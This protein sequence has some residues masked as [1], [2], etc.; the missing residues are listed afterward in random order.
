MAKTI[1]TKTKMALSLQI[2]ST[3][4]PPVTNEFFLASFL[5]Y[6]VWIRVV[7]ARVH[8]TTIMSAGAEPLDRIAALGQMTQLFAQAVEDTLSTLIAWSIWATKR[9]LLLADI[10][11]RISLRLAVP[12]KEVPAGYTAEIQG[13][14]AASS[15]RV[16]VY[17]RRYLREL[18]DCPDKDLP[19]RLGA[20]T[21]EWLRTSGDERSG[22]ACLFCSKRRYDP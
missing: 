15:G 16:E 5:D 8:L 13:K 6:G 14:V 4:E 11:N 3:P 19:G 2:G 7:A 22:P 21:L 9:E 17:P 18:I 20:Q 12:K 10:L 1:S